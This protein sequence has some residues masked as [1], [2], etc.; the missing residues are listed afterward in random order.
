VKP[1][2]FQIK[3]VLFRGGLLSDK[4][5]LCGLTVL[6]LAITGLSMFFMLFA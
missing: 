5:F 4:K 2:P 3:R 6:W 1:P